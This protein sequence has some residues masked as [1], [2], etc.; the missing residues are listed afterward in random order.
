M[1]RASEPGPC[2][3]PPARAVSGV[4]G[5]VAAAR[6]GKAV[7]PHGVV[8]RAT[9]RVPGDPAAPRGSRLLS[10]PDEHE[11]IVR[12]SRP[13]GL[14]RRPPGPL[15][16]SIRARRLRRR[17]PPGPSERPSVDLPVVHHVFVPATRRPAAHLQLV[18]AVP[19]RGRTADRRR[20]P[21]PALPAPGGNDE[22]D[23][24]DRAAATGE[25][26][27]RLAVAPLAGRIRPI[28]ELHI[29]E[30]LGPALDALRFNRST[31]AAA[32][33]PSGMLNRWRGARLPDLA[34]GVAADRARRRRAAGRGRR[35]ASPG[36][37]RASSAG[38]GRAGRAVLG[39]RDRAA[40][41]REAAAADALGQADL[42]PLELGDPL[43]DARR[44]AARQA[45]PVA[46]GR[47]A[48]GGQ[49]GELAP[50][51]SSVSPTRCAKTMNAIRRST[52]RG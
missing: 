27:F 10:R 13:V 29:G 23:R 43:V 3:T 12:F 33:A 16:M 28:A 8:H 26:R 25:L 5:A 45:R 6:R 17:P 51:S 18:A 46:P 49:L 36:G 42:Q 9:L 44:P 40:V 2:P 39:V 41:E 4:L 37:R 32:C 21:G 50:I 52:G 31:A 7:H 38:R 35:R 20:A 1:P 15:G 34:G 14:P 11:A 22:L 48:V 19:R 47:R 30:R 24:R